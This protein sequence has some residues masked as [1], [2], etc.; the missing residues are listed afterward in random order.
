MLV[1]LLARKLLDEANHRVDY[2]VDRHYKVDPV[3]FLVLSRLVNTD[4]HLDE[5]LIGNVDCSLV[6]VGT[7]LL[8][9]KPNGDGSFNKLIWDLLG[10]R[11]QEL[12]NFL[13]DTVSVMLQIFFKCHVTLAFSAPFKSHFLEYPCGVFAVVGKHPV[14]CKM[15]VVPIKQRH[16]VPAVNT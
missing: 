9:L 16:M 14:S 15:V 3:G 1:R 10:D 2:L 5:F 7:E 11:S 12:N 13:L 8:L 6:N 4:K